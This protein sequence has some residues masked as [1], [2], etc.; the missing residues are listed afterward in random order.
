MLRSQLLKGTVTFLV[1]SVLDDGELYGYQIAKRIR[2]RSAAYLAPSEGSLYPALHA[3]E[4]EGAIVA[5]WRASDRGAR[6]RYYRLTANG[7]RLLAA[8][9]A[10]WDAFAR[11]VSTVAGAGT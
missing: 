10:D 6:R 7:R 9:R 8:A 11:A 1:L 5:D 2:E 4:R 3:L